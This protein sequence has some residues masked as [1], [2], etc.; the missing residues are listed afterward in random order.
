MRTRWPSRNQHVLELVGHSVKHLEFVGVRRNAEFV[1][2]CQRRGDAADVVRAECRPQPFM[3]PQ[4]KMG[5]TFVA[6]VRLPF[7]RPNGHRPVIL[8]RDDRLVVPIG[9]LDETNPDRRAAMPRPIEKLAKVVFRVRQVRLNRDADVRPIAELRLFENL[10]ENAQRRIL[11]RVLLHVEVD[12][13]SSRLSGGED[14]TQS[15]PDD[16]ARSLGVDRI[17]LAVKRR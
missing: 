12:E 9:S 14:G 8:S 15:P 16:A 1:G 7:L 10:A 3:I 6:R 13:R 17:E 5:T 2:H 11:E 4:Q